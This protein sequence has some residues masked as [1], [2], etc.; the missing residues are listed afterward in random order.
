M[1]TIE[2]FCAC[3]YSWT[4]TINDDVSIAE[5]K[6]YFINKPFNVGTDEVEKIVIPCSVLFKG[7]DYI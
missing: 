4:T 7:I 2:I 5:V 3:G 1:Q 6:S